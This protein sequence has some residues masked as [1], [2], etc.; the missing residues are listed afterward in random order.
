MKSKAKPPILTVLDEAAC[1]RIHSDASRILGT[2]GFRVHSAAL[3]SRLRRSGASVDDQ[4]EV[5]TLPAGLIDDALSTCPRE[6]TLHDMDGNPIRYASGTLIDTMCT[7]GEALMWLDYREGKLVP[8]K[9]R[10]LEQALR[11]ADSLPEIS[12]V[13]V[14]VNPTDVPASRQIG[15]G[16]GTLL[17]TTRKSVQFQAHNLDHMRLI[18]DALEIASPGARAENRPVAYVTFSPISPCVLD[19]DSADAFVFGIENGVIS[20]LAS[21]PMAGATSPYSIIGTVLQVAVENLFMLS[22]KYAVDPA[23][24]CSWGGGLAAMDMKVGDVSYGGIERSLMM[25]ANLD[26]AGYFGLP[27]LSSAGSADSCL[28]DEQI[29]IEKTWTFF[30]R[31]LSTAATGIYLGAITNGKAVSLEQVLIDLDIVKSLARFSE[32]IDLDNY[33]AAVRDVESADYGGNFMVNQSTIDL[34]AKGEEYYYPATFNRAGKEA[35]VQYERAHEQVEA[36]LSRWTNPVPEGVQQ[37]LDKLMTARVA[38]RR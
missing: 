21:C 7:Y 30:T 10:H 22:A 36:L 13:S 16:V 38:S 20:N 4:R 18:V 11:V 24:P 26:M 1:A 25:L 6:F 27:C 32:G 2:K 19:Q 33:T 5:V 34:L 37:D 31:C 35:R 9:S 8:S 3:R 17:K 28:A 15:H 14:V 12:R 23:A 29:G